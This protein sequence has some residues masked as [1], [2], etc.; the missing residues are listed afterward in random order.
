MMGSQDITQGARDA[1][2]PNRERKAVGD[3]WGKFRA[4]AL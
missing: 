4:C 2:S 3:I 1:S